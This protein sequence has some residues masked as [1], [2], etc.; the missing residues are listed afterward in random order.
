MKFFHSMT[1]RIFVYFDDDYFEIKESLSNLLK[2]V[3]E[4]KKI[5]IEEQTAKGFDDNK[6]V[7]LKTTL[8]KSV[9]INELVKKIAKETNLKTELENRLSDDLNIYLRLKKDEFTNNEF[10]LTDSGDCVHITI[11]VAAYP[12]TIES[13]KNSIKEFVESKLL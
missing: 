8:T 4:P 9:Q 11:S 1:F 10:K 5:V 2:T 7:I 12:K 13:A 3:Q 6:I